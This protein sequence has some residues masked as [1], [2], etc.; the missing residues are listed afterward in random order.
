[1]NLLFRH[2]LWAN[3]R[4]LDACAELD[5]TVLDAPVSGIFDSIRSILTHLVSAEESYLARLLGSQPSDIF[6]RGTAPSIAELRMRAKN[7]GEGLMQV[8]R[9]VDT[10]SSI[11]INSDGKTWQVPAGIALT[12]AIN[13]ATEHRTEVVMLLLQQGIELPDINGWAYAM[14]RFHQKN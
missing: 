3:L 12:Q 14:H 9:E 8:V 10:L 11:C 7:S 4:L 5:N 13:H 2:H 6:G 1:M